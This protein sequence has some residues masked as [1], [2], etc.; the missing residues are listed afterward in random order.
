MANI[1]NEQLKEIFDLFDADGS[2]AIDCE[3]LGT[4]FEG[5]G[6]DKLPQEELQQMIAEVDVDNSG[7]M[8]FAEFK[9]LVNRKEAA[10]DSPEE[11]HAAFKLF[12]GKDR[13]GEP[14]AVIEAS[15]IAR[16]A[17]SIGE[18]VDV[19]KFER[20]VQAVGQEYGSGPAGQGITFDQWQEMMKAVRTSK[21]AGA[22]D[23]PP[24]GQ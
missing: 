1:S 17:K 14:K 11:V 20:I 12:A 3:E 13:Y 15:D 19:G 9:L 2:G 21:H 10:K 23:A 16:I 5:L 22:V 4:V 8:E 7:Q 24:E 6:F 18:K